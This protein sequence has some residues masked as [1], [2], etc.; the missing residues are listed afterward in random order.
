MNPLRT[1]WENSTCLSRKEDKAVVEVTTIGISRDVE[2]LAKA[3]SATGLNI[4]AGTGYYLDHTLSAAVKASSVEEL[5]KT[6]VKELTEGVGDT[7]IKCGR[8][9]EK[10]AARGHWSRQ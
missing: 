3:A 4:I 2:Y 7:S 6:M 10:L 8:H 5:S 1:L 9:C